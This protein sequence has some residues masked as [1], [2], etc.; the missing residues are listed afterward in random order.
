[1]NEPDWRFEPGEP[2]QETDPRLAVVRE[3]IRAAQD[4]LRSIVT[5][6]ASMEG[7]IRDCAANGMTPD[8]I[9]EACSLTREAVDHVLAGGTLFDWPSPHR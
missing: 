5:L 8:A 2:P 7:V 1:M 3:T 6:M 9:A 4:Q